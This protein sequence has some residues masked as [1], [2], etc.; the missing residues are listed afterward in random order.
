MFF[1]LVFG[2]ELEEAY[3]RPDFVGRVI[4]QLLVPTTSYQEVIKKYGTHKN[5]QVRL[6]SGVCLRKLANQQVVGYTLGIFILSYFFEWAPEILFLLL[7]CCVRAVVFV[8]ASIETWKESGGRVSID[9][10]DSFADRFEIISGN[11]LNK[12]SISSHTQNYNKMR[13]R[14]FDINMIALNIIT[15]RGWEIPRIFVHLWPESRRIPIIFILK[16]FIL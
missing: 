8:R 7:V 12:T 15:T 11:C 13:V 14:G 2:A 3:E 5:I 10:E 1:S 9:T 6:G 16:I 4:R